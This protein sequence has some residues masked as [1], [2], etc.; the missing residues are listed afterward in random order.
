MFGTEAPRNKGLIALFTPVVVALALFVPTVARADY[1]YVPSF[2]VLDIYVFGSY[3]PGEISA[4]NFDPSAPAPITNMSSSPFGGGYTPQ[5]AVITPDG[6]FL[7]VTN[8]AVG[9]K[10]GTKDTHGDIAGYRIDPETGELEPLWDPVGDKF[11]LLTQHIIDVFGNGD[12]APVG[13]QEITITPDGKYLYISARTALG[14]G[15]VWALEIMSD[16]SLKHVTDPG[17]DTGQTAEF[18]DPDSPSH[19]NGVFA[20]SNGYLYVVNGG[21][22]VCPFTDPCGAN[23]ESGSVTTYKISSDGRLSNVGMSMTGTTVS[24]GLTPKSIVVTKDAT[25]AYVANTQSD[26]IANISAFNI[27]SDG[28]L[29]AVGGSPFDMPVGSGKQFEIGLALARDESILFATAGDADMIAVF[30][31]DEPTGALDELMT[32]PAGD[33]PTRLAVSSDGK[34]LFATNLFSKD[35]STYEIDEASKMVTPIPGGPSVGSFNPSDIVVT[36]SSAGDTPPTPP[37]PQPQPQPTPSPSS[38]SAPAPAPVADVGDTVTE[39]LNLK[40]TGSR[41][42]RISSR[43]IT[44][45]ASCSSACV[46]RVSGKVSEKKSKKASTS[47]KKKAKKSKSFRLRSLKRSLGTAKTVKLR[48]KLKGRDYKRLKRALARGRSYVARITVVATRGGQ[49]VKSKRTVRLKV[50]KKKAGKRNK[51]S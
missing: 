34:Y 4:F 33:Q 1:V 20:A 46:L 28:T 11:E 25:R 12:E 44:V 9:T 48:L 30:A 7:Y 8:L 13:A 26:P 15:Q 32:V 16:G 45:L 5:R 41:S 22:E 37:G 38:S 51:K 3:T 17:D 29:Q 47:A 39:T 50:Q 2:N 43:G 19:P 23:P 18:V 40:L 35:V 24:D 6:K 21:E 49:K 36:P 27:K 42:Q 31:I 14:D 10:L